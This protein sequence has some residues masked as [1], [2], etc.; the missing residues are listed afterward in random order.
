MIDE[1]PFSEEELIKR[2]KSI[3]NDVSILSDKNEILNWYTTRGGK[4]K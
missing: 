2:L 1:P 4:I 3:S